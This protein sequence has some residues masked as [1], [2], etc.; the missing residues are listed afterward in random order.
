MEKEW[1]GNGTAFPSIKFGFRYNLSK[2]NLS[3]EENG[4]QNEKKKYVYIVFIRHDVKQIPFEIN[5][6]EKKNYISCL[7]LLRLMAVAAAAVV[8]SASPQIHLAHLL[9]SHITQKHI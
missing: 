1:L 5:K 9:Q 6:S 4:K 2:S 3:G 7:L 8:V